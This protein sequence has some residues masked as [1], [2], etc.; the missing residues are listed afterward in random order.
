[1]GPL[2]YIYFNQLFIDV[3]FDLLIY[4]GVVVCQISTFRTFVSTI[5]VCF[6]VCV[7]TI[8]NFWRS[9]ESLC[10]LWMLRLNISMMLFPQK[11]TKT[12]VYTT[13]Y[14]IVYAH[15]VVYIYWNRIQLVLFNNRCV[16][17]K[18]FKSRFYYV[19]TFIY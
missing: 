13:T 5:S 6:L 19:N 16:N 11:L 1:M 18:K 15:Y 8:M 10:L 12:Y 2:T 17:F 14:C 7:V 9:W 3:C 4:I